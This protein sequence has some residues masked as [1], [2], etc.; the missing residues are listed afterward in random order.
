MIQQDTF[1]RVIVRHKL[2]LAKTSLRC[3][4][5]LQSTSNGSL[6]PSSDVIL[7]PPPTPDSRTPNKMKPSYIHIDVPLSIMLYQFRDRASPLLCEVL[8]RER[9]PV[10]DD[11]ADSLLTGD[12]KG[13]LDDETQLLELW[14]TNERVYIP[15][16]KNA[17]STRS[18][19]AMFQGK[20]GVP[21]PPAM[22]PAATYE[23]PA[24]MACTPS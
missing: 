2:L 5:G 7:D 11:A 12:A 23:I 20:P 6:L 9:L 15:E 19:S 16:V 17:T 24:D 14:Q 8:A 3:S 10:P 21:P 1:V 18:R 22:A 13:L 4:P